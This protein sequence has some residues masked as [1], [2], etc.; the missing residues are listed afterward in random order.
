MQRLAAT[1]T[2]AALVLAA[3][4]QAQ[5]PEERLSAARAATSAADTASF[6]MDMAMEIDNDASAAAMDM[7]MAAD[8]AVD[9]AADTARMEMEMPGVGTAME[10]VIDG[11]TVYTH[12]PPMLTGD[13][14]QWVRQDAHETDGMDGMGMGPQSGLSDDPAGMVETL[15]EVDGEVTELGEDEVRGDA[16]QGYGFTLTGADLADTADTPEALADLE[17]P[18]EAWLDADDRLRR[19]VT[20]IDMGAMMEAVTE[21]MPD[22]GGMREG[23][24]GMMGAMSGTMTL[25]IEFFDFGKPVDIQVPDD[26]DVLD[27]AELEQ[28]MMERGMPGMDGLEGMPGMDELE[29]MDPEGV[30]ELLEEMPQE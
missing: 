8:G 23:L 28:Q 27:S 4:G 26:A 1:A 20:E 6:A 14:R 25:T 3:C 5:A 21:Q 19:M 15:D 10:T 29:G 30:E 13:E 18:A 2:V 17:I 9:F 22:D 7:T 11:D 12:L 16:V 24:A